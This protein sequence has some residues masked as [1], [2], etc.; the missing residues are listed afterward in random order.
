MKKIL[1]I[2]IL[3]ILV[4]VGIC[5]YKNYQGKVNNFQNYTHPT[6]AYSLRYP[7]SWI[8]KEVA[9]ATG[10][11]EK[12]NPINSIAVTPLLG[13]E[14]IQTDKTYYKESYSQSNLVIDGYQTFQFT[15]NSSRLAS[16]YYISLGKLDGKNLYLYIYTPSN[17]TGPSISEDFAKTLV[18]VVTSISINKEKIVNFTRTVYSL[19]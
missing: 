7:K 12:D 6:G 16:R 17:S 14:L 3:I 18:N 2:I 19:K 1:G 4:G 11:A 13:D 8:I 5:F 9:T 15:S 10:F